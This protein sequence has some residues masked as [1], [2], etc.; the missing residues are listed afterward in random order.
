MTDV[1]ISAYLACSCGEPFH[2]ISTEKCLL[3]RKLEALK[4]SHEQFSGEVLH[5]VN[6]ERHIPRDMQVSA[7]LLPMLSKEDLLRA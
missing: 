7:E 5:R 3:N 1:S 6:L 4:H 2:H